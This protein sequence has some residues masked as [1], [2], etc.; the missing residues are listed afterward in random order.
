VTFG[1]AAVSRFMTGRLHHIFSPRDIRWS[2]VLTNGDALPADV[3]VYATAYGS[4]N[5]WLGD[6][7]STDVADRIGKCW[8]VGSNTTRDPGPWEGE[9]RNMWKPTRQ[10]GLWIHGGN[11]SQSRFYSKYLALQLKA[12]KERLDTSVWNLQEVHH[13]R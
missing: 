13:L 1:D 9:L 10:P 11:L 8:G 4:M 2:D 3:I 6:L 7:I 5:A 12:R